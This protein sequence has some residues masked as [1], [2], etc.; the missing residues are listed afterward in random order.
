MTGSIVLPAVLASLTAGIYYIYSR[1]N[2]S[3]GCDFNRF[4][5]KLATGEERGALEEYD[6][7]I[8]GGGK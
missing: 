5:R 3:V 1:F 6:V 7:V 8:V 4:A 2:E